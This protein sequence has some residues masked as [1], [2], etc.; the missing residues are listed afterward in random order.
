MDYVNR[1]P[2][3]PVTELDAWALRKLKKRDPGTE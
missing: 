2:L 1:T 3:Y